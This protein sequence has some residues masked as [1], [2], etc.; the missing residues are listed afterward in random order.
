M[1]TYGWGDG[2]RRLHIADPN[3]THSSA[4]GRAYTDGDVFL[5]IKVIEDTMIYNS[6]SIAY[7]LL[8][9]DGE[10]VTMLHKQN[11]GKFARVK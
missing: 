10:Q 11:K 2:P 7:V 8:A 4:R 5:C 1:R 9:P 3:Y 6:G